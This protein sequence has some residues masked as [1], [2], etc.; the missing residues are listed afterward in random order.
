MCKFVLKGNKCRKIITHL[1]YLEEHLPSDLYGYLLAF[2]AFAY[3]EDSTFGSILDPFYR[4]RIADFKEA[5]DALNLHNTPKVIVS[6][7]MNR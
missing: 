1:D 2:K 4:D 6:P 5:F 3:L 7:S